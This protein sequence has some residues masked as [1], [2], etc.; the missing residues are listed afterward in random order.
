VAE[1]LKRRPWMLVFLVSVASTGIGS[2]STLLLTQNKEAGFAVMLAGGI[3]SL[4][5][6]LMALREAKGLI[7]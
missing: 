5:L 1:K 7:G 4:G 3:V 2:F 6:E